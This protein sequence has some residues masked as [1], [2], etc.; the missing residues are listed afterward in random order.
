MGEFVLVSKTPVLPHVILLP[1]ASPAMLPAWLAHVGF[2]RSFESKDEAQ[3][4]A[5]GGRSLA[6]VCNGHHA[7]AP[8]PTS[9]VWSCILLINR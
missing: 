3:S 7:V 2:E 6:W 5:E 1:D 8:E 9:W 4:D